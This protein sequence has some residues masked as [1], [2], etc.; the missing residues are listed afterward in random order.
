MGFHWNS[1]ETI[2]Y[3]KTAR[4]FDATIVRVVSFIILDDYVFD[5]GLLNTKKFIIEGV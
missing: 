1:H 2:Q 4:R 3:G 5:N